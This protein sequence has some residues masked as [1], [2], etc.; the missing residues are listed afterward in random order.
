MQAHRSPAWIAWWCLS[1]VAVRVLIVWLYNNT[2][3]SVFAEALFHG[4]IN[5]KCF[6]FPIYGS[7]YDPRITDLI[8]V[9]DRDRRGCVGA[10]NVS[11]IRKPLTGTGAA[12]HLLPIRISEL[13]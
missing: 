1:T 3:K 2:G 10:K 7:H 8:I 5:V 13:L 6:L 9:R 12:L 11:E 4:M